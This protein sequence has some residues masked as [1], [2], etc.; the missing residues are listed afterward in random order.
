MCT[1]A[2]YEINHKHVTKKLLQHE[3][4]IYVYVYTQCQVLQII[5]TNWC[6]CIVPVNAV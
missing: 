1:S 5:I 3:L 2:T 4:F 6:D